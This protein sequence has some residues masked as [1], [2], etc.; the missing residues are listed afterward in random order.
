MNE[1]IETVRDVAVVGI[2]KA[3]TEGGVVSVEGVQ[4]WLVTGLPP[5]QP[6]GEL[7]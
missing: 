3:V 2:V 4:D 5:V 7:D 1:E 6:E